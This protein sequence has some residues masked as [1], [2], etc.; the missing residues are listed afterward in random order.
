MSFTLLEI[1][2]MIAAVAVIA[3]AIGVTRVAR[4]LTRTAC[5]IEYAA[6]RITALTPTAQGVLEHCEAE[7]EDLRTLTRKTSQIVGAGMAAVRRRR[8]GNEPDTMNRSPGTFGLA[9]R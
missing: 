3:S 7:L 6:R 2:A 1:V 8:G 9:D 4:R 5:E